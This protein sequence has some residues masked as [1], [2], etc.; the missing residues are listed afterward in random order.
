MQERRRGVIE[1][2][3]AMTISG[4]IGYVVLISGQPVLQ[5]VF[6]RCLFGALALALLCAALGLFRVRLTLRQWW[7]AILGGVAIVL[8][9]LLL[10]GAYAHA[11][12][13]VATVVYNMQPF[14]LLL[15]GAL[16]FGERITVAKVGWL[17]LAFLGMVIIVLHRPS[18]GY[19][20][21]H[22]A[23]GLLMALAAAGGWAVAALTTKALTGVPPQLIALTHVCVGIVLLAPF[24]WQAPLPASSD[25]W[26]LL[27]AM[28]VVHT[29]LMYA[30]MYAAVQ[31]LPTHLQGA[32][33]FLYPAVTILFD[34]FGL[35][36]ALAPLQLAGMAA[37]LLAAA[38]MTLGWRWTFT[39]QAGRETRGI[40]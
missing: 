38:G 35:G 37:I 30:L 7:L 18:A 4:S 6:F 22:Y 16:L 28:G 17:G 9:W 29:G 14:M 1:M 13:A 5:V 27:A 40:D 19:V 20:G 39:R 32:L 3:A 10:F 2:T 25:T 31:R 11:S 36:H 26:A 34:V 24:V 15:A 8:N 21:G 23:L 33:S 12:V